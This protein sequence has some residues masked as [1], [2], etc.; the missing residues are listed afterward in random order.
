MSGLNNARCE[1]CSNAIALRE[2]I[3]RVHLATMGGRQKHFEFIYH[4]LKT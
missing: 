4:L 3:Q 1:Q 2:D